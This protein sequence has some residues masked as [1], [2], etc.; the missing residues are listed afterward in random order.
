MNLSKSIDFLLENAG[1]V[2]KY[3]LRKEI[4]KDLSKSEEENLLEKVML[5]PQYK[6][7]ESYQKPN[8]Y[9]G[10]GMHSWDKFKETPL[11]DG[12]AASRL[13]SNYAIPRDTPL[14]ARFAKALKDDGILE[15]EFSYYGPEAKRFENR[16]IGTESGSSLKLLVDLF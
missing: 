12:E 2:I 3:R 9:I 16:F 13:I 14:V 6:L 5:T 7:L 11:Q 15:E 4:L 8:G 10:V 1:D